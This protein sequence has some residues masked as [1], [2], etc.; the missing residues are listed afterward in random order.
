MKVD[1]GTHLI[2]SMQKN[3]RMMKSGPVTDRK[4]ISCFNTGDLVVNLKP[5]IPLK[6]DLD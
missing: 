3:I 6:V 4:R 5:D 2:D 1:K